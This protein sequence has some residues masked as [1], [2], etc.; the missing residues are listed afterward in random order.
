MGGG[1]YF[2]YILCQ[3]LDE[4]AILPIFMFEPSL[5]VQYRQSKGLDIGGS[6]A[7]LQWPLD[8]GLT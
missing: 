8:T 3:I 6:N 2:L 4:H 1:G 7:P 5:Y